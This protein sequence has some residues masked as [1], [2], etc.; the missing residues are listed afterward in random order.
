MVVSC[1]EEE[2]VCCE[3]CGWWDQRDDMAPAE[4]KE[5]H[6]VVTH[7]S[8]DADRFERCSNYQRSLIF[9][10]CTGFEVQLEPARAGAYLGRWYA[11]SPDVPRYTYV[12]SMLLAQ[13]VFEEQIGKMLY[14]LGLHGEITW[15]MPHRWVKTW[16]RL[17]RE[18]CRA[19]G[20]QCSTWR[21]RRSLLT[22]E[23]GVRSSGFLK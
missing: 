6:D 1:F 21:K 18:Q 22:C 7:D 15:E 4:V 14:E 9:T 5:W 16:R 19:H 10:R 8:S 23:V 20:I 3:N 11:E 13:E 17:I 2:I 12:G